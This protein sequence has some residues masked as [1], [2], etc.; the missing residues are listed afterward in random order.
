MISGNH[1]EQDNQVSLRQEQ[2][3]RTIA[4]RAGPRMAPRISFRQFGL[5]AHV[6]SLSARGFEP[7]VEAADGLDDI[8]I[9]KISGKNICHGFVSRVILD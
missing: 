5:E 7:R 1:S 4:R 8:R 9:D 2:R 6:C 3:A